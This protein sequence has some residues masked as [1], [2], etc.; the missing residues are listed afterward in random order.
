MPRSVVLV[1]IQHHTEDIML[2]AAKNHITD[3][4]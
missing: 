2:L 3:Y 4:I 1:K